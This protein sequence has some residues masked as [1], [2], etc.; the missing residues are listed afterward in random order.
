MKYAIN[1]SV[2][3][4]GIQELAAGVMIERW[5]FNLTY[6]E[7]MARVVVL[8]SYVASITIVAMEDLEN[9]SKLD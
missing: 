1:Y 6:D 2:L 8:S 4:T 7:Y 3:D 9:Y 5:E